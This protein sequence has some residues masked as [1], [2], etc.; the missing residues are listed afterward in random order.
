MNPVAL[1]AMMMG[2]PAIEF[3]EGDEGL[4]GAL[5]D[6]S[7][8]SHHGD[9]DFDDDDD[10][11]EYDDDGGGSRRTD[12]HL[13]ELR[14]EFRPPLKARFDSWVTTAQSIKGGISVLFKLYDR[15]IVS[16]AT[17]SGFG[18]TYILAPDILEEMVSRLSDRPSKHHIAD[19][20]DALGKFGKL[21]RKLRKAQ[22]ELRAKNRGKVG[23]KGKSKVKNVFASASVSA[24]V[25]G[26]GSE[27]GNSKR[28]ED[29]SDDMPSLEP[30][31][32]IDDID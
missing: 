8:H 28:K 18:M 29:E 32:V 22:A 2:F 10:E 11:D 4:V 24:G 1:A 5:L 12:W 16:P 13:T 23:M 14:E 31:L 21:V 27:S 25:S 19:A 15:A 9:D 26:S 20:L 17:G 3:E 6:S 7:T 30:V